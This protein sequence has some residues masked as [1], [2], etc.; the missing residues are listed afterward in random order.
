MHHR[1]GEQ[2]EARDKAKLLEAT[3]AQQTGRRLGLAGPVPR[4]AQLS[5]L[6]PEAGISDHLPCRLNARHHSL[7]SLERQGQRA[8]N[9]ADPIQLDS[10]LALVGLAASPQEVGNLFQQLLDLGKIVHCSVS[11]HC[12]GRFTEATSI[13]ARRGLIVASL[14]SSLSCGVER[15]PCERGSSRRAEAAPDA[16]A[17]ALAAHGITPE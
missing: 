8:G 11:L 12:A 13:E 6:E 17:K 16:L 9:G 1:E 15:G 2:Y 3:A 4:R 7:A 14:R 5:C 10:R